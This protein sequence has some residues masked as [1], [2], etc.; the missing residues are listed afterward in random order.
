MRELFRSEKCVKIRLSRLKN[1]S[2]ER[3]YILLCTN[4][5][6]H[7][8]C[9]FAALS[10]TLRKGFGAGSDLYTTPKA[11]KTTVGY[12]LS[13]NKHLIPEIRIESR[14]HP[15]PSRRGISHGMPP[16][17]RCRARPSGFAPRRLLRPA[18]GLEVDEG[19][20]PGIMRRRIVPHP[21][22]ARNI[23]LVFDGR[24]RSRVCHTSRRGAGHEAQHRM[25]S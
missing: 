15:H 25:A 19:R 21:V 5:R 11:A 16:A 12:G 8:F 18:C 14:N 6:E 23:A 1:K 4:N 17:P 7:R 3:D 20:I 22:H 13:Y 10:P 24:A 9:R 2:Q